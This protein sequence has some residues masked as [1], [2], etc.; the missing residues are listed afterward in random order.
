M[1]NLQSEVSKQ[2]ASAY[3]KVVNSIVNDAINQANLS[4]TAD[5][6]FNLSTGI[7]PA[8]Q[9]F[10][11]EPCPF[12]FT[13]GTI[14]VGQQSTLS[15]SLRN[16]NITSISNTIKN[17]VATQTEQWI[18][19]NFNSFQGWL[20]FAFNTQEGRSTTISKVSNDIANSVSNNI[21]NQCGAEL[22]SR[23][24][25]SIALCGYYTND[26]LDFSQNTT[27]ISLTSCLNKNIINDIVSNTVVNEMVQQTDAYFK[28]QEEGPLSG[29]ENIIRIIVIIAAIL[30]GLLIIGGIIYAVTRL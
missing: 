6:E 12:G 3:N 11:A 4:C 18:K 30:V 2:V 7:I 9:G 10:P 28:S 21:L 13:N 8:S 1:G 27:I 14:I 17:N 25:Q 19:M 16:Q 20:A 29:A 5:E 22:N 26:T 15:C 23:S 24:V